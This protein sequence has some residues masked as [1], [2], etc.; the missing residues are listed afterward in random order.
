MAKT[1]KHQ[2]C[3][4]CFPY[5]GDYQFNIYA[6]NKDRQEMIMNQQEP[7]P[8]SGMQLKM[9]KAYKKIFGCFIIPANQRT[10]KQ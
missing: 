9:Q 2:F 10:Q 4:R 3:I 6:Y 1:E 7:M 5:P 8:D